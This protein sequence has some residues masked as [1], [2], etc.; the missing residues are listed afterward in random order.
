MITK[1][2]VEDLMDD[3]IEITEDHKEDKE[4]G[5]Y[6]DKDAEVYVVSGT[7]DDDT[8][9]YLVNTSGSIVKNKSGAKNGEDYKFTVED[10]EIVSFK[11]E[12]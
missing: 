9:Y 11:L 12:N 3:S 2:D 8:H 4:L 10:Q 6:Y 5:K 7:K 1:M